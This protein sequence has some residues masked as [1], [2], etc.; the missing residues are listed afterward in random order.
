MVSVFGLEMSG[1]TLIML[2]FFVFLVLVLIL[3]DIGDFFDVGGDVGTDA[4]TGVSPIS[5][6]VVG[7][8]GT[9]FGA[10]G[11][12]FEGIGYTPLLTA[13][14]A[15]ALAGLTAGGVWLLMFNVFVKAQAE[16]RVNLEDLVGFKGQVSVPIRPGQPGQIV[17]VTEAR[18]RTLLQAI[19]DDGIGTDEHVIVE[20]VVGNSVKVRKL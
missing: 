3:G 11:T 4:D 15:V 7:A 14:L 20:S 8:F 16:T 10:F 17:V 5:L 12:I 19:A 2:I 1:Y 18:G 9:A 13:V 6:P